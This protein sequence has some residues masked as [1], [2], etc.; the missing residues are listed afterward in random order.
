M[1]PVLRRG[2]QGRRGQGDVGVN[3][4]HLKPTRKAAWSMQ[5]EWKSPCWVLVHPIFILFSSYFHPCSRTVSGYHRDTAP[6]IWKR[7]FF[8]SRMEPVNLARC[9]SIHLLWRRQKPMV[10]SAPLQGQIKALRSCRH[11]ETMLK[12]CYA[13]AAE[14]CCCTCMIIYDNICTCRLHVQNISTYAEL[15][16]KL[17]VWICLAMLETSRDCPKAFGAG[18]SAPLVS[19]QID[20]NCVSLVVNLTRCIIIYMIIYILYNIIYILYINTCTMIVSM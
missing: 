7:H 14:G 9:G 10:L 17:D 6:S 2:R 1:V 3:R 11:A 8:T 12:L 4:K 15:V 5:K 16:S 18:E 13:E 20:G 19:W